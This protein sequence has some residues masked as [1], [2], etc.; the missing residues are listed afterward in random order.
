[1]ARGAGKG[2]VR[3]VIRSEK[4]EQHKNSTHTKIKFYVIIFF[5]STI[6]IKI[7]N[8]GGSRGAG[9]GIERGVIRSEKLENHK[10]SA[11]TKIKFY[12]IF[13]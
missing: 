9:N 7:L 13:I 6:D 4:W 10:N 12:I 5:F 2:M 8:M 3:G 1:M 11:H